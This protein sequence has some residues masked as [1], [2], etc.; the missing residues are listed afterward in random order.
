MARIVCFGE[1]LLRLGAPRR[2]RLLQSP[3]F[4]VFYGG[5]EA[6]VAIALA[7][8]GHASAMASIVPRN[9]LGAAA[10]GELRR[11]GVDT[12]H[13]LEGDGRMGLYYLATGAMQR[14]SEVL[15]DRADSAFAR[16]EPGVI[17]WSR[18]LEGATHLHLSGVSPALGARAAEATRRAARAGRA[19]GLVVSFDGNYRQ[20]LWQAWDGDSRAILGALFAEVDVLFADQRDI[21]VALGRRFEGADA[22]SQAAA[23]AFAAYPRL[24]RIATTIRTQHDVDRHELGAVLLT[25]AERFEA[26]PETLA[27]IVDRIGAGDAF[28]AGVLHGLI[29]GR[30]EGESLRLGLASACLKHATP[31]DAGLATRA[32]LDA[33]GAERRYDV[34]R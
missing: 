26:G 31:G 18:A 19:Q 10:A 16:A 4:E 6:N 2:E 12:S 15:Y 28:A 13:V 24:T 7:R 1:L 27:G 20:K 23:A 29:E 25:R 11:Q 17:D 32:E 33:F 21:G 22:L 9:E 5:A 14:P 8:L 30:G 3:S 34:R